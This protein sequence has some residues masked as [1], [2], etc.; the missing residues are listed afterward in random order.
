MISK[1]LCDSFKA[2]LLGME[3][4]RAGD[5]YKIALYTSDADLS[6]S[7]TAYSTADE[8]PTT[9]NYSP[10]G[11]PLVGFTVSLVGHVAILDW[12]TDPT[13]A[14]VTMTARGALIYNA[15]RGNKAVAV[16]NFGHDVAATDGP[17]VVELPAPTPTLAVIRF[18]D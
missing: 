5:L 2:E 10:G 14:G 9:G 6:A 12:T 15:T 17:F 11:S 7:T 4:H 13:W 8:V 18:E 16:L 3:T 1:A